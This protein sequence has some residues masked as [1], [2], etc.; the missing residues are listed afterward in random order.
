MISVILPVYNGEKYLVEC[1]DSILTQTFQD[2]ELICIDDGSKDKTKEIL[3]DYSIKDE[4]VR[5]V[6]RQN[7]GL[8]YSLNEGIKLSRFDYVARMDADDIC[9]PNRLEAQFDYMNR[10][11]IDVLGAYYKI[12]DENG[13]HIGNRK[14]PSVGFILKSLLVFGSPFG[15][16]TVMLNKKRIGSDL[17][18]DSNFPSA[19]D[20]ELWLRLSSDYKFGTVDKF[21]LRYRVIDSSISRTRKDE[22]LTSRV[23]ALKKHLFNPSVEEKELSLFVQSQCSL[24]SSIRLILN[25][26]SKQLAKFICQIIY[27]YRRH[28]TK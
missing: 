18:Y 27:L 17:F 16:P 10:H 12:I 13:D 7:M 24:S 3:L 21:L 9:E 11:N 8:I 25:Q 15:H 26:K 1:L 23:K 20:Y 6:S 2:F 28:L 5:V 19:E 14:P 4:R 22:Q